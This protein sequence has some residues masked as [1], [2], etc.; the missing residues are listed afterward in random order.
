LILYTADIFLLLLHFKTFFSKRTFSFSFRDNSQLIVR[1]ADT[2]LCDINR[3]TPILIH[4]LVQVIFTGY[5]Q[6]YY[7]N[8]ASK[9]LL[10][11]ISSLFAPGLLPG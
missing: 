8:V 10:L 11:F 9:D 3:L 7:E 2:T 1:F 4:G 5:Y 6:F